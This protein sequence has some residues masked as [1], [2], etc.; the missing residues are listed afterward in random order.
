[1]EI[2][3]LEF[4]AVAASTGK[5][6]L[7]ARSLGMNTSAI[8]RRIGRLEDKVGLALFERGPSG[9]R[10][11]AGG[12]AV[13]VHVRRV[14]AELDLV[15]R[16]GI[17]NGSG[18]AGQIRLGVR[19]PPIGEPLVP[20]LKSWR[21]AHPNVALTVAEMNHRDLGV[22]LE[23]RRLDVAMTSKNAGWLHATSLP[24]HRDQLVAA[25]PLGH[26]L[27]NRTTVTWDE[28]GN[29]TCLVQ[30]WDESQVA[31]DLYASLIGGRA[32]FQMHPASKQSV[33]ALV[34]AGFGITLATASQAEVSFP[35]VVFKPIEA[36]NASIQIVLAWLPELEDAAV[37]RFVAFLRDEAGS[38]RLL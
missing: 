7:A 36:A 2:R 16:T 14:L 21:E 38:A 24:I 35:G 34:A 33:F 22:T 11:T 3:A 1:M 37:G 28:L 23:E 17:E 31:R 12:K 4:L 32:K 6:G 26:S 30:G 5:F 15:K 25:L 13:M 9:V 19:L 29:E 10:L 8:S 18:N 20:L 27:A